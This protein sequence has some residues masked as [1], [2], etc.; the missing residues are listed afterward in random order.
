MKKNHQYTEY[1][2]GIS[3]QKYRS[4]RKQLKKLGNQNLRRNARSPS[5]SLDFQQNKIRYL[6]FSS[7][8]KKLKRI[9]ITCKKKKRKLS[10]QSGHKLGNQNNESI[11]LNMNSSIFR[12]Q[13]ILTQNFKKSLSPIECQ[14]PCSQGTGLAGTRRPHYPE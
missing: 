1:T 9:Q 6:S 11:Q 5:I 10:I 7:L 14:R 12:L 13:A 8:N 3:S 4:K 2:S